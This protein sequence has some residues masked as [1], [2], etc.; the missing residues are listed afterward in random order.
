MRSACSAP[1]RHVAPVNWAHVVQA[2]PDAILG[3]AAAYRADPRKDKVNLSVGAYRDEK[4]RPYVLQCVRKAE[5]ALVKSQPGHEYLPIG[6]LE[7]FN[8]GARVMAFGKDGDYYDHKNIATVQA[9]SGTGALRLAGEFLR[10]WYHAPGTAARGLAPTVYLPTPTWGNH[11][12]VFRDAGLGVQTYRYFDARTGGVD[13]EGLLTDVRAAPAGSVFLFHAC[14]HNPTGA[15]PTPAEWERIRAACL[16]R[17]HAVVFDSAYQGFASGDPERDAYALRLFARARPRAM[18]LCQSF[19]KNLGMYGERVGALHVLCA[20]AD[21]A[22]RVKSQVQ[23]IVRPMYSSPPAWGAR[24]ASTVF[25]SPELT[26]DWAADMRRMASR[27]GDMRAALVAALR[28]AGSPRNWDHITRQ[29]GMFSFTGLTKPQ[30]ASMLR[31]HAVYL[32]A[33]GRISMAGLNPSNVDKVA[34]A[35]H[36]ATTDY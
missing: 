13:I 36:Q 2:P 14:A 17:G 26:A 8:V 11:H 16:E 4:G 21:E 35:M 5:A 25:A 34:R 19:A 3:V 9:L 23:T 31:D 22:A 1:A 6:G 10:R 12:A 32:T 24:L 27:I 15:D 30:C 33:N 20:S 18:L 29:I 28:R 7:S